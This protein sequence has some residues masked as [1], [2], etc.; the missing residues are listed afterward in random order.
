MTEVKSSLSP[1]DEAV[2]LRAACEQVSKQLIINGLPE[3]DNKNV[4]LLVKDFVK[5]PGV[6]LNNDD[7]VKAY[8]IR[9]KIQARG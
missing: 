1:A 2:L 3:S 9:K 7:L 8:R 5:T 4:N 6:Q